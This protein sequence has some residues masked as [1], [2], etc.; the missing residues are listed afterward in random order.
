VKDL[1]AWKRME[2]RM[3]TYLLHPVVR[4]FVS[5]SKMLCVTTWKEAQI[6]VILCD[7][8]KICHTLSSRPQSCEMWKS[9]F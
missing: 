2:K 8:H 6:E 5:L 3:E 1:L 9:M 7:T 4:H